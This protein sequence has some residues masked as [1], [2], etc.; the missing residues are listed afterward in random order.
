MTDFSPGGG[1]VQGTTLDRLLSLLAREFHHWAAGRPPTGF[2]NP[3]RSI[4]LGD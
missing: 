3:P 4:E 1:A 2:K